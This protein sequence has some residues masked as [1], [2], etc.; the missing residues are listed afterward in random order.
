LVCRQVANTVKKSV[1]NEITK[2]IKEMGVASLFSIN[3]SNLVITC[4]INN[5][6]I[7]FSGLD[8]SEKIKSITPIDGVISDI[9]VEEATESE[10]NAIKQLQK[11][12]RGISSVNKR[13]ILS[14]NPILKEHWIY[15]EYFKEWNEGDKEYRSDKL[16]ILHTTYKDNDFLTDDDIEA[17]ENET[18][19]YF[20]EVYTLGKWGV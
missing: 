6:Q 17:L 11:R 3:K 2:A 10:Y 20:Y 12:L 19:K 7:M 5:K 8:D 15:K 14:F 16:S 18:D 4:N 1:F 13:L 9:W